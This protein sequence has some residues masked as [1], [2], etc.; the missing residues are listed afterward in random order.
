[1][2]RRAGLLLVLASLA[3]TPASAGPWDAIDA[4]F[5]RPGVD[6][7]QGVRRYSFPRS[8][9]TVTLDGVRVRPALALGSWIAFQPHGN[10]TVVMGDLVLLH[11]EVNPVLSRL[12]ASGLTI[13]ALH[14]H[15]LRSSPGTMY[16]HVHGHGDPAR[17]A[18]A[19]RSALDLTQTPTGRIAPAPAPAKPLAL[20]AAALDRCRWRCNSPHK[21]RLNIPHF[22]EV[23]AVRG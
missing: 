6:Q 4:A 21:W 10:A 12:L 18:A 9:L 17:I 19:I 5:G 13:T 3:A 22:F 16:M 14:N 20:N 15:L 2:N 11:E 7:A 8:D 1:L 23:R